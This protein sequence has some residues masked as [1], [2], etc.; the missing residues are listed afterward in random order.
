MFL[1]F[2]YFS[3]EILHRKKN[4]KEI[5]LMFVHNNATVMYTDEHFSCK[6]ICNDK[7]Q[8]LP[9]CHCHLRLYDPKT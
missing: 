1:P 2:K 3:P 7:T 4:N 8:K 9:L 5:I 6:T